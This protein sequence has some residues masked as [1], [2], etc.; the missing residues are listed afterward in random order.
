[1]NPRF[2]LI[3]TVLVTLVSCAHLNGAP[4]DGF[5]FQL[6]TDEVPNARQMAV[7]ENGMLYVGTRRVGVVYAVKGLHAKDAMEVTVVDS[8]LV[9]PSGLAM[10]GDDLIVAALNRVLR[11]RNIDS[12]YTQNP[13]P[14]V[15]TDSLPDAVAHGWKYVSVGPDGFL[16]LNVGAPCNICESADERF[17]SIVRM[18]P[19]TGE[20]SV[21]A[22]GVRNTVGMAW[23]PDTK[24]L[25]FSDNGRD[26]MGDDVPHEEINVVKKPGG[27][28][29]YPYVHADDVLDPEFGR[30]VDVDDYER[31]V[32]NIQAH[33]AA[34][35]IDFYTHSQ[36]PERYR[37]ALFVAEH[38]SW[39][40]SKRV[41]YR[42]S[43][44][45]NTEEGLSYEPF[46]DHWLKDEKISGR[47]N[48]VLVLP[49]GTLLIS[50]DYAG[51]IY[52][53]RY[54]PN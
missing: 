26:W 53:V 34:L 21:Y 8:G 22:H 7:S 29:G 33:S 30:G 1:M 40:R 49:D 36:F 31:P 43:V 3:F 11:Y 46:I 12:T 14:E 25:W 51:A 54:N 23:H 39:N 5:D 18:N 4:P 17:A 13:E 2:R 32:V 28:F 20:T 45:L 50:D 10:L 24:E 35:G 41:G 16:Y 6:F 47:P 38:G 27:H 48:D 19:D 9:M 37:G 44:V 42:V 52:R 15:I